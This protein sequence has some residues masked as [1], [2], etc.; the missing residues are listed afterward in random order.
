MEWV[1]E[2]ADFWVIDINVDLLLFLLGLLA[3][4]FGTG[5]IIL[6]GIDWKKIMFL[7]V[8]HTSKN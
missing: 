3:F 4:A 2:P 6:E 8:R 5:L 1:L 7:T